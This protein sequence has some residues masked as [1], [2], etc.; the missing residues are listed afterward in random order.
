MGRPWRNGIVGIAIGAAGLTSLHDLRGEP[1]L[2]GRHL[3]VTETATADELA[4]AAFAV[5][6]TRLAGHAGGADSRI[7][8]A[9]TRVRAARPALVRDKRIDMFR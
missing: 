4:S 1:D 9:Q 5:A 7:Y 6:G 2:F 3:A 8:A